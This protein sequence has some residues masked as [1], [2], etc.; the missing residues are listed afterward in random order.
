M[1][2]NSGDSGPPCGTPEAWSWRIS[3]CR[4]I[5]PAV[6]LAVPG[7][8]QP[9]RNP[10]PDACLYFQVHQPNRLLPRGATRQ[11]SDLHFEDDAVNAAILGRVAD[12]CYLPANRMFKRLIEKHAGRFSMALSI[13]GTAIEQM[14]RHRPDVLES[15]RE[16]VAGMVPGE[17]IDLAPTV[18]PIAVV[19]CSPRPSWPC[20]PGT[21]KDRSFWMASGLH[22]DVP[23]SI[24]VNTFRSCL[25]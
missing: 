19:S 16:L 1:L 25:R 13:S 4:T 15:F 20:Q 18:K 14:E 7:P 23:F 10:M 5:W 2:A 3:L 9:R 11:V 21:A 12:E 22:H 8:S 6:C 24:A 17:E